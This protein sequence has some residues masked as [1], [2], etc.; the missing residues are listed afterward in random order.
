MSNNILT[1]A[2]NLKFT[3]LL[4]AFQKALAVIHGA[5]GQPID[6]RRKLIHL[7]L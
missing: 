5:V 4:L 1:A 2:A 6:F 7:S 3:V